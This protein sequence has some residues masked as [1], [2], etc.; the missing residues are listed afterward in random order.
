MLWWIRIRI[1]QLNL[2]VSPTSSIKPTKIKPTIFD[3]MNR[4]K[5]TQLLSRFMNMHVHHPTT[6]VFVSSLINT[7]RP[8]YLSQ[9]DRVVQNLALI[10]N[11]A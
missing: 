11:V 1:L 9:F 7:I 6:R 5:Y 4:R 3:Y 2:K 10:I 8:N